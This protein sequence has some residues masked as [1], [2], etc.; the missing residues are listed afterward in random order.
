[1]SSIISTEKYHDMARVLARE[2]AF[3]TVATEA[4]R[5]DV[6]EIIKEMQES[7]LVPVIGGGMV[8]LSEEI[9]MAIVIIEVESNLEEQELIG[10]LDS[11]VNVFAGMDGVGPVDVF[12]APY[13]RD[14][15]QTVAG[16]IDDREVGYVD[17]TRRYVKRMDE[18]GFTRVT[19]VSYEEANG[20]VDELKSS[21]PIDVYENTVIKHP[22]APPIGLHVLK[23]EPLSRADGHEVGGWLTQN[24]V[25]SDVSVIGNPEV[26]YSVLI[27]WFD[28][29]EE[30]R[31]DE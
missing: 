9:G 27:L 11:E 1:M 28:S 5:Q 25:K 2:Y 14:G 29:V 20:V 19:D 3:E 12:F 18:L 21:G 17:I 8:D 7:D 16:M 31:V 4:N 22:E 15:H 26:A 30:V 10:W 13:V 6:D 23:C 24:S